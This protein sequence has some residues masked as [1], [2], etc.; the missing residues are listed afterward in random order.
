MNNRKTTGLA[1]PSKLGDNPSLLTPE[2]KEH[3]PIATGNCPA[4]DWG[5]HPAIFVPIF[6]N[7]Y[8]YLWNSQHVQLERATSPDEFDI[9]RWLDVLVAVCLTQYEDERKFNLAVI[10]ELRKLFPFLKM[11]PHVEFKDENK[12]RAI[13]VDMLGTCYT[14]HGHKAAPILVEGKKLVGKGGD[15][16]VQIFNACQ[17]MLALDHVRNVQVIC[18]HFTDVHSAEVCGHHR[19]DL[20][21]SRDDVCDG[22]YSE[23]LPHVFR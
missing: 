11:E 13:E 15:P 2:Q 10:A 6:A 17:R 3:T 5:T 8:N 4:S 16:I 1:S 18:L 21:S 12:N 23:G 7:A 20:L 19:V 22:L 9:I 14:A